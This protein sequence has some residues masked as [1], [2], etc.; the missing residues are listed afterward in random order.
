MNGGGSI[1]R[2]SGVEE[3]LP[4]DSVPSG[5]AS[6]RSRRPRQGRTTAS[7]RYT[8]SRAAAACRVLWGEQP[9]RR[10]FL[11]S[12]C[13]HRPAPGPPPL[14]KNSASNPKRRNAAHRVHAHHRAPNIDHL[15]AQ[16]LSPVQTSPITHQ[17][18]ADESSVTQPKGA[19]HVEHC[20][21]HPDP[22]PGTGH[23][24]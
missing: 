22:G 9:S 18:G 15:S 16:L 7:R 4:L 11:A 1:Y 19:S 8:E 5:G 10:S 20:T 17:H 14:Q 3:S 23:Q 13:L 2:G 24:Y 12:R 21:Q 6:P